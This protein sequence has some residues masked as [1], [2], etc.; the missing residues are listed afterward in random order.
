MHAN[1]GARSEALPSIGNFPRVS[2]ELIRYSA[3]V[4]STSPRPAGFGSVPANALTSKQRQPAG[5]DLQ[6]QLHLFSFD[7]QGCLHP[8]NVSH[9]SVGDF[10]NYIFLSTQGRLLIN[11]CMTERTICFSME[12]SFLFYP[13]WNDYYLDTALAIIHKCN[14]KF[15]EG[16]VSPPAKAEPALA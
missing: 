5:L 12:G 3:S 15:Y 7:M 4:T 8:C 16:V 11:P 9:I 13:N 2:L 14:Q 6:G 10:R 1:L